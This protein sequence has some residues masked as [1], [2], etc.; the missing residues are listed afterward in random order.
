MEEAA[1][2]HPRRVYAGVLL[3]IDMMAIS[4]TTVRPTLADALGILALG[5]QARAASLADEDPPTST[6]VS[7]S[8]RE[9]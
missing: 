3:E 2:G 5:I 9:L 7:S 1:G 6:T 8:R 4:H